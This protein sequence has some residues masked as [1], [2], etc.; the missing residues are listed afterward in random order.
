MKTVTQIVAKAKRHAPGAED[1][2]LLDWLQTAYKRLLTK[3]QFRTTDVTLSSIVDGTREYTW[4]EADVRC[5]G[6]TWYKSA[7]D[8]WP[9]TAT[10]EDELRD[11]NEAWK[12]ATDEGDPKAFYIASRLDASTNKTGKLVIGFDVIPD[13]TTSGGYP[14]AV[15]HCTEHT[16]ISGAT[17]I[18]YSMLDEMYL[19]WA[20]CEFWAI[21]NS[22]KDVA[23]FRQL[24]I[25]EETVQIG[26]LKSLAG[27]T[28]ADTVLLPPKTAFSTSI[29]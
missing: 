3:A 19:V 26:Y 20:M 24:R 4:A 9:L 2:T 25:E 22:K 10:S 16:A 18:P 27:D 21:E 1:A 29:T 12:E 8:F 28:G 13:T 11:E 7:T 14:K 17:E 23:M 5:W 6:V 15:C